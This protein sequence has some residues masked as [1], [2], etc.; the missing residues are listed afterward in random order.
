MGREKDR[1]AA[2]D[3]SVQKMTIES[4]LYKV[5]VVVP[6]RAFLSKRNPTAIGPCASNI[7]RAFAANPTHTYVASVLAMGRT[8]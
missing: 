3:L 6:L 5:I 7:I 4:L 1:G 8:R 2:Q